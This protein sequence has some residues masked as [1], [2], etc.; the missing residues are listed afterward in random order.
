[1]GD[2]AAFFAPFPKKR[3]SAPAADVVPL[4]ADH[5]VANP[6]ERQRLEGAR[7][8]PAPRPA[9]PAPPARGAPVVSAQGQGTRT[10]RIVQSAWCRAVSFC[11]ARGGPNAGG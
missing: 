1:V 9:V 4:T 10:G 7:A 5:R 3:R 11:M 8:R 2:S 6:D